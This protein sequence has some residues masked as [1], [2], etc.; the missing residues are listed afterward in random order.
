MLDLRINECGNLEICREEFLDVVT[1]YYEDLQ[2]LSQRLSVMVDP[3]ITTCKVIISDTYQIYKYVM[4]VNKMRQL[5]EITDLEDDDSLM[6][7]DQECR[8]IIEFVN[9]L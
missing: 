4:P 7:D 1:V 2:K 8:Q 6:L 5:F 9:N 3:D